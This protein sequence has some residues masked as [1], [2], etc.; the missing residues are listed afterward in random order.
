MTIVMITM[1]ITAERA[2]LLHD[3][4]PDVPEVDRGP[5]VEGGSC[6]II[7]III[8]IIIVVFLVKL[9]LIL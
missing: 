7:I 2:G 1:M 5:P 8:I 4:R 9:N 3:E 6:I